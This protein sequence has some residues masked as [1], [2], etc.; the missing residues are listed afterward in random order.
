MSSRSANLSTRSGGIRGGWTWY[1]TSG[2]S[3]KTCQYP[4]VPRSRSSTPMDFTLRDP[5]IR[6]GTA[7]VIVMDKS[8]ES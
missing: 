7:A 4:L 1:L 5:E 6:P 8:T 2:H 3:G